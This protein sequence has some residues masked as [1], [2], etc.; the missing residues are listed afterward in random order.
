MS[1]RTE[2]FAMRS[3][4]SEASYVGHQKAFPSSQT[5]GYSN[6][7]SNQLQLSSMAEERF[8]KLFCSFWGD[9]LT[10]RS[11]KQIFLFLDAHT[12][13]VM[14]LIMLYSISHAGLI[15]LVISAVHMLDRFYPQYFT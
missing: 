7:P 4:C 13:S 12:F 14:I 10:Y 5:T 1:S 11:K 9:S 15:A 3:F 2:P 8:V 6:A